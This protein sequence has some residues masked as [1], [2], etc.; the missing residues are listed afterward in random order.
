[1][2]LKLFQL[3]K[4][5]GVVGVLIN[6]VWSLLLEGFFVVLALF[7][8]IF[9]CVVD[10]LFELSK[11]LLDDTVGLIKSIIEPYPSIINAF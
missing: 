3:L 1:M 5:L 4:C 8:E 2:I 11:M 10:F 7:L 6:N 9:N